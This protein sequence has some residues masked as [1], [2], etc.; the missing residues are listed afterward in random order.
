MAS[1]SRPR[2]DK[3][4]LVAMTFRTKL[5]WMAAVGREERLH[6]LTIAHESPAKALASLDHDAMAQQESELKIGRWD[7]QLAARLEAYADGVRDDFLDIEIEPF[8]PGAFAEKV[9]RCCRHIP[10]GKTLGYGE[11]ARKAGAPRGARAVGNVMRRNRISLIVPCHRVIQAG[12]KLGGYG[13]PEGVQLKR[14]LLTLEG[15]LTDQKTG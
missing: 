8:V 9:I 6:A 15:A 10:W 3:T 2:G 4:Q 7:R 11:L 5:G 14:Q 12:G 13:S 1:K